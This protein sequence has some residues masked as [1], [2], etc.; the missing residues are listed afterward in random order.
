MAAKKTLIFIAALVLLSAFPGLAGTTLPDVV[1][2][3]NGDKI[4]KDQLTATLID[5]QAPIV[6][7]RLITMRIIGQEAKKAGINVTEKQVKAEL[8]KRVSG[9]PPGQSVSEALKQ[10]GLTPGSAF[11]IIKTQLQTEGVLRKSFKV[12]D[13]DLE[14]YRRASQILI[15]VPYV[16]GEENKENPKDK[17]AKEKIEKIAQEIKDGLPFEE[18]AKKYSEDEPNKDKGG[19]LGFLTR[20]EMPPE[21]PELSKAVFELKPGEMSAP[22]KTVHGYYLLKLT[23]LGKDAKGGERKKLEETIFQSKYW[24][25]Y[26]DWSLSIKNK[27]KIVNALEPTKLERKPTDR[28]KPVRQPRPK[29]TPDSTPPPPP[30]DASEPQPGEMPPPP[31]PEPAQSAPAQAE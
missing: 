30:E 16:P 31:P 5:W 24:Q 25:L 21:V 17:E 28:P 4:T 8:E 19:D 18:A 26:Q 23:A 15:R 3:V 10:L 6:L 13:S 11:A 9:R 27:A 12:T 22:V 2:V 1:A 7:E 29:P 20:G 14:N